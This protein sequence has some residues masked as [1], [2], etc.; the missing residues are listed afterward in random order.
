MVVVTK[1]LI[2][3]IL[4]AVAEHTDREE[5][6]LVTLTLAAGVA[7]GVTLFG[8]TASLGAFVAGLVVAA[9]PHRERAAKT[10]LPFQ[11]LFAAIFFASIGMLLDLS[12]LL[13]LWDVVL[14][15]CGVVVAIKFVT[16]GVAA[17]VFGRPL[18]VV[19]ASAFVLAQIGEFS[20]IL[21]KIG[22]E[23]GL[24]PMDRGDDGSQVF[25]A[26][27]VILIALTP[28]LFAIGRGAHRRL[29]IPEKPPE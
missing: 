22:R 14:L 21:E 11:A 29:R 13:D 27:T 10:I 12:A 15:F 8:L 24:T 25:I 23:N 7:Y 16:T 4:D 26:V 3:P 1:W 28:G 19:A 20:F 18:P 2:P 9:G 5:F 6:L 17:A